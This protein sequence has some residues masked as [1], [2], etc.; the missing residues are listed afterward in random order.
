MM[1]KS[2]ITPETESSALT[3]KGPEVDG[4]EGIQGE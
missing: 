1:N 4:A 2:E 3:S